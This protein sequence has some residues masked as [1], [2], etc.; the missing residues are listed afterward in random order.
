VARPDGFRL[1]GGDMAS[2]CM[3]CEPAGCLGTETPAGLRGEA[4][5]AE[6]LLIIADSNSIHKSVFLCTL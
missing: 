3:E 1:G 6:R 2:T 4:P 5:E